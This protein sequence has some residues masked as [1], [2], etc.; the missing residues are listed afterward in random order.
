MTK[1]PTFHSYTTER[2]SGRKTEGQQLIS[3]PQNV[4]MVRCKIFGNVS[5]FLKQTI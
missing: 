5:M 1:M 4:T 2:Q 3:R